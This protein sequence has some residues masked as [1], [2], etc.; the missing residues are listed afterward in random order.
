MT[1]NLVLVVLLLIKYLTKPLQR[2]HRYD[3]S[4]L[5]LHLYEVRIGVVK[6]LLTVG[7]DATNAVRAV[8]WGLALLCVSFTH[9]ATGFVNSSICHIAHARLLYLAFIFPSDALNLLH[10]DTTLHQVSNNLTL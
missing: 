7:V 10:I 9:A 8:G 5:V 2:I 1:E 6:H 3:A 4:Q